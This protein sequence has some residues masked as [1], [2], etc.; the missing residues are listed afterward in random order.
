MAR[1]VVVIPDA[2]D[3]RSVDVQVYL[4]NCI[5]RLVRVLAAHLR[6]VLQILRGHC[7]VVQVYYLAA[8]DASTGRSN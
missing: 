8:F 5:N 3:T 6:L 4:C 2:F 7:A 1:Q